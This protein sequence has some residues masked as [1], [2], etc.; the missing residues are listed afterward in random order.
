[1]IALLKAV[2]TV[3]KTLENEPKESLHTY[4]DQRVFKE[5]RA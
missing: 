3:A 5:A 2:A 1:M 4:I